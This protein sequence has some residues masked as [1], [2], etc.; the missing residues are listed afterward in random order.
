MHERFELAK[1]LG[2]EKEQQAGELFKE[3][4]GIQDDAAYP[5]IDTCKK[6]WV[7]IS[8]ALRE[9]PINITDEKLD[10]KFEMMT[11]MIMSHFDLISFIIYREANCIGQIALWHRLLGYEAIKYM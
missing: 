4:K 10:S 1:M 3:H 9:G 8:P 11:G 5:A 2:I 7:L 6:D